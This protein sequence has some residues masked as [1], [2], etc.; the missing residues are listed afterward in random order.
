[1]ESCISQ[2]RRFIVFLFR[3]F[4]HPFFLFV[5]GLDTKALAISPIDES[6]HSPIDLK[7][8][9]PEF[10]SCLVMPPQCPPRNK[11]LTRPLLRDNG[12]GGVRTPEMRMD[13]E[14]Y[15]KCELGVFLSRENLPT[16][17][18]SRDLKSLVVNGD[19][20]KTPANYTHP[21]PLFLA[22]S[23]DS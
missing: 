4:G 20:F 7:L 14:S 17:R 16:L 6:I 12:R 10:S 15:V 11:A 13:P 18:I 8:Q 5:Y 2:F 23:S 1:M 22:G 3:G 9:F 19:L 21:N